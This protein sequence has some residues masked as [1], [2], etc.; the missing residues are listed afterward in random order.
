[1][2]KSNNYFNRAFKK[3]GVNAQRKYPNE[4]FCRFIGRNYGNFNNQ[5]RKKIKI[6]EVGCGNGVHLNML[7]NEGFDCYGIDKSNE[8]IKSSKKFLKYKL[9]KINLKTCDMINI[10]YQNSQFD[11]IF[12][13]FSSYCLNQDQGKT[14]INEVSRCLKKNGIFFSV[15]PSK[16]SDAWKKEKKD[17]LIDN[18]TIKNFKRKKSPYFNN[19][20][21]F[22]FLSNTEY[23]NLLKK[24]NFKISYNESLIRT[25]NFQK[26][27][28][29][30]IIVEAIKK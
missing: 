27:K 6:L 2:S 7:Y 23:L 8:A 25:Y 11:C 3:Y 14:F 29:E 20:Y 30:F 19:Q 1:M 17:N 28:F 4:E 24:N 26:E 22:R 9:D 10:E 5:K 15:F 12:D 13:I 18:F 16:S 21:P